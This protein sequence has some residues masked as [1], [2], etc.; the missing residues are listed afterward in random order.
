MTNALLVDRPTDDDKL[1]DMTTKD[2]KSTQT[3][4]VTVRM[5]KNLKDRASAV[6]DYYGLDVASV[7]RAFFTAIARTQ[8]IPLDFGH[9]GTH[10]SEPDIPTV[11]WEPNEETIAAMKETEEMIRTGNYRSYGSAREMIEAIL[12]EDDEET[13]E[14]GDSET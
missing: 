8:S 9:S 7:T 4:S 5:D 14:E 12:A 13:G 6:I 3:V 1:D 10:G 11:D 2:A